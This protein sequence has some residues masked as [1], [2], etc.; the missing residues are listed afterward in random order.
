MLQINNQ[1]AKNCQE[2]QMNLKEKPRNKDHIQSV[3][4]VFKVVEI[5]AEHP[6]GLVLT[7]VAE[8][9]SLTR[10]AARRYLLSLVANGYAV[11]E[12]RRFKLSSRIVTVARQWINNA[13]FWRLA[14]P[15]LN[16]VTDQLQESCSVAE[17]SGRDI[18]YVARSAARRIMAVQISVGT[19]LPIYCTSMGQVLLAHQP[20]YLQDNI[21]LDTKFERG[22]DKSLKNTQQ[23]RQRIV[24]IKRQGYAIVDE[25]L[26]LGICSIA[27]PIYHPNGDVK[28]A[29]NLSAPKAR[30]STQQ[31]VEQALP[32]LTQAR[33]KIE[34]LVID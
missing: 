24:E 7:E 19:Q 10:P 29:L 21:I 11:Q 8:L 13:H 20:K 22:S 15:I 26:E 4:F 2:K 3:E 9:A 23:I 32:L 1:N 31:L 30:F 18:V 33:D 34:M 6:Y 27:I 5:L 25:E 12:K 28:S 16:H 17:L 14:Q